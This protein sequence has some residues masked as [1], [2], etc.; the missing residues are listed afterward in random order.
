ML[1]IL[2]NAIQPIWN[3]HDTPWSIEYL[4]VNFVHRNLGG[5]MQLWFERQQRNRWHWRCWE[6][7]SV[8]P[9]F[10]AAGWY[11]APSGVHRFPCWPASLY[12]RYDNM[13]NHIAYT[14][15]SWPTCSQPWTIGHG[16]SIRI[17]WWCWCWWRWWLWWWIW[18]WWIWWIWWIWWWW[19]W[20]WR[21]WWTVL[22]TDGIW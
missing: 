17:W 10:P 15:V 3:F 20:W 13:S 22:I 19:W 21:W 4:K 8:S 18:W 9:R 14:I 7:A 11:R 16:F 12:T 5:A 6:L 1:L 2:S